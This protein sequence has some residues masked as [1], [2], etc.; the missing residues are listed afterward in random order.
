[1]T[2][3][4]LPAAEPGVPAAPV[5]HYVQSGRAAWVL[6]IG[7]AAGAVGVAG[8]MAFVLYLVEVAPYVFVITPALVGIP[9]F[10][11]LMTAVYVGKCRSVALASLLAVALAL[12]YYVGYWE[13]SY[14]LRAVANG[15]RFVTAVEQMGGAPGLRATSSSVVASNPASMASPS[16]GPLQSSDCAAWK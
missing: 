3:M 1:M 11:A 5:G 9:V 16:A 7:L 6:F 12:V 10:A 13:I 14:R 8:A 15:P 4:A 2:V